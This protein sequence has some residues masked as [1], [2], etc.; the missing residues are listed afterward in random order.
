MHRRGGDPGNRNATNVSASADAILQYR[1]DDQTIARRKEVCIVT[2]GAALFV[3][4]LVG[5]LGQPVSAAESDPPA[6]DMHETVVHVPMEEKGIFGTSQRELVATT[7][8]P[9]GAGPFPLIVLSHGN[10]PDAM[11]RPK[12]GRYRKLAQIRE[13]VH[14]GFVVIVPIRRGYGAT[15][16]S[17]AED[18]GSCKHPNFEGAGNA[19]AEDLLA[20]IKFADTLPQVD[21]SH[22]VLVGQSAGGFA[23]LAAASFAPQGLVAVVNFSGGSGGR[24]ATHPGAPCEPELMA[25]AIGHFAATTHVPALWHYVEN[26]E[27][28]APSVVRTWFSAF[29]AAGG[30]GELVME[31]P[32]GR[33]GHGMFAVDSAIPIWMPHFAQ[34]VS[35]VVP[36][37]TL[38]AAASGSLPTTAPATATGPDDD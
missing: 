36:L 35:A 31:P 25:D 33:K 26:D 20:T 27:F 29:Q 14:M 16:G 21:R 18:T 13:F 17:Y 28:F 3:A 4:M 19:A 9:D 10:P 7:Y 30:Q 23:S 8:M 11:D 15:G 1:H 34:F 38:P 37:T 32:F 24:P 5:L 2:R 22:V 6:T 12:I